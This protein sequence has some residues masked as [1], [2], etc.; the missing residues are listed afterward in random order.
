MNKTMQKIKPIT[1][2]PD[3]LLKLK[4]RANAFRG[5][6]VVD[7]NIDRF[8]DRLYAIEHEEAVNTENTLYEVRKNAAGCIS[9]IRTDKADIE[10]TPA[11][12]EEKKDAD[13]RANLRNKSAKNRASSSILSSTSEIVAANELII[14]ESVRLQ[15]RIGKTRDL[16]EAKIH[17]YITG[18]R[19]GRKLKGYEM[20]SRN[21]NNHAVELYE[22]KHRELDEAIKA[23]SYKILKEVM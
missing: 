12:L 2:M 9:E 8:Y 21:P 13:V 17:A 19:S 23:V 4:G 5:E 11:V 14:S 20:K 3:F 6:A 18:V 10:A 1:R 22:E 15:Q 7:A 16:A